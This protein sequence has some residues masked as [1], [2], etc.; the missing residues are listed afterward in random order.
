MFICTAQI[1][2]S[3]L[4]PTFPFARDRRAFPNT[5]KV[6]SA[7]RA[8]SQQHVPLLPARKQGIIR[9]FNSILS[10]V[11][12]PLISA[13]SFLYSHMFAEKR[14]G[15]RGTNG[16][17]GLQQPITVTLYSTQ[18]APKRFLSYRLDHQT[19][20]CACFQYHRVWCFSWRNLDKPQQ[21]E[22]QEQQQLGTKTHKNANKSQ[23]HHRLTWCW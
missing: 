20:V 4:L 16:P 13:E 1:E 18:F 7:G 5:Q 6:H 21:Q 9:P 10:S 17:R 22:Q 15:K 14:R 2:L 3:K 11:G 8:A 12:E 19:L 23:H